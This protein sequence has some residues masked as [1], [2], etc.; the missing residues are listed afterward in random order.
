LLRGN[1]VPSPLE[2]EG[3]VRGIR[4]HSA[5]T[6]LLAAGGFI[7]CPLDPAR[8]ALAG[9]IR[10]AA[11]GALI[12]GLVLVVIAVVQ[13]RGVENIDHLV[14][15][16]SFAKIRHPMYTGFALWIIGWA[17]YHGALVSLAVGFAGIGNILYWRRL[18]ER[19]LESC[20]KEEYRAYRKKTW[21]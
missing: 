8:V 13:L 10:W 12:A 11:F 2:G 7:M 6:G 16:G 20:Y 18:E 14:T 15:T 9:A 1:H 17:L 19:R 4:P 3:R 21:F 5:D